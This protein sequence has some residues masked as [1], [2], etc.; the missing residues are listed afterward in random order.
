MEPFKHL[1]AV[2]APIEGTGVN[3]DQIFPARFLRKPRSVGYAQFAFHDIR[4]D[5][6]GNFRDDFPLNQDKFKDAKILVAGTNFGIGSS[7]EG[8]VY[9][10]VDG[11]VRAVLANSFGDIYA[12]NC[13]KNGVLVIRLAPEITSALRA[14]LME[15]D[16]PELDI[17]LEKQIVTTPD[18]RE[19]PFEIDD[20][21]KHCLL[22]GLNEIDLSLEFSDD[23][24]AFEASY[25]KLSP[26]L[27]RE[28]AT[29]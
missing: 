29:K 5:S 16:K 25:R 19:I 23:M 12:A 20:F 13:L 1:K 4:R 14:Q 28:G 3:T 15:V 11:G 2:A 26:W 21:Q 9:T 22:N 17:D 6:D 24:D 27:A 8:A 10:M 7:R 18:G